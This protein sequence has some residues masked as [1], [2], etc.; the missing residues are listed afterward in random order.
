MLRK[1]GDNLERFEM[2]L[3]V[4]PTARIKSI[5]YRLY[6]GILSF[7]RDAIVFCKKSRWSMLRGPRW[8]GSR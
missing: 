3:F 5:C 4:Y 2:Y 6:A 1:I 8:L 7:L